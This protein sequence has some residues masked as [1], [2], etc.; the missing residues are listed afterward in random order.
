MA[1][2][3]L[4]YAKLRML[5]LYHNFFENFCVTEKYEEIEMDIDS[6]F[7]ALSEENLEKI[8]LPEKGNEWEA[9]RSRD[10]T[11]SFTVNATDNVFPKTCC[12][13]HKKQDKREPGLPK[14]IQVFRNVVPV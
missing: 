2:F 11:D 7:L 13:A 12:T 6:V 4:E 8:I 10:C 14:K 1:F 5:D 9:I 3:I